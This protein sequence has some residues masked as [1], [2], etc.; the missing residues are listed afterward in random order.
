MILTTA[1]LSGRAASIRRPRC[2]TLT[3]TRAPTLP[4]FLPISTEERTRETLVFS[5]LNLCWNGFRHKQYK[6]RKKL[7][8]R[9]ERADAIPPSL[10]DFLNRAHLP[11]STPIDPDISCRQPGDHG[12][13]MLANYLDEK[14]AAIFNQLY[15]RVHSPQQLPRKSSAGDVESSWSRARGR[16]HLGAGVAPGVF[17]SPVGLDVDRPSYAVLPPLPSVFP[18]L[19]S[20][21]A[22]QSQLKRLPRSGLARTIF[23]ARD[24]FSPKPI[25][26]RRRSDSSPPSL[27]KSASSLDMRCLFPGGSYP[28]SATTVS[29]CPRTHHSQTRPQLLQ[30]RNSANQELMRC[31]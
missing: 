1:L 9:G 21:R 12:T 11:S 2:G 31:I 19:L 16:P 4:E 18:F 24:G 27:G 22:N 17:Q 13:P 14:T 29:I 26:G 8:P 6:T 5:R 10:L 25:P 23:P 20:S 3:R 15:L 28:L 30:N 7:K